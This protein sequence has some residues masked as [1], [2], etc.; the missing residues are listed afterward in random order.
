MFEKITEDFNDDLRTT[1]WLN[2]KDPAAIILDERK[3]GK[4]TNRIVFSGYG[5]VT[6]E[7]WCELEQ[8]R[9]G[10]DNVRIME[11]GDGRI[12]LVR[13]AKQIDG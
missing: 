11:D 13:L 7:R 2:P 5:A 12:A 3:D 9:I 4:K 1:D 6:N 10:A 8:K